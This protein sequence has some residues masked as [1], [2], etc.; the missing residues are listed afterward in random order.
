[1]RHEHYSYNAGVAER[2]RKNRWSDASTHS[3][4]PAATQTAMGKPAENL[5]RFIDITSI[6]LC[7]QRLST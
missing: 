7:P 5:L 2:I 6:R 3:K 1:M 4:R